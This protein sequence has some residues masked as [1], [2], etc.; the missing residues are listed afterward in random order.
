MAVQLVCS[1]EQS[2]RGGIE[3]VF[4]DARKQGRI[5]QLKEIIHGNN[6]SMSFVGGVQCKNML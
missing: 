4:L 1:W 3:Y 6:G 5:S 2:I